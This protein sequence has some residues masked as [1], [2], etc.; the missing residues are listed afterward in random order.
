MKVSKVQGQMESILVDLWRELKYD[1]MCFLS[2][3]HRKGKLTE[4]INNTFIAFISKADNPQQL[5]DLWSLSLVGV[6]IKF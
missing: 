2:E 5:A 4:G 1:F 3:F 6:C